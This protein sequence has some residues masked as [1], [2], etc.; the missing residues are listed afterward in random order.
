MIVLQYASAMLDHCL[1]VVGIDCAH[2]KN[3]ELEKT[4]TKRVLL[5]RMFC[6]IL[7]S[8]TVTNNMIILAISLTFGSENTHH[9][10]QFL[11]F[12]V[13][14]G[15]QQLN[16]KNIVIMSDR[17]ASIVQAVSI[18]LPHAYHAYCCTHIKRNLEKE[19]GGTK[20]FRSTEKYF[21]QA[22]NA[23]TENLY[24]EAM[25]DMQKHCIKMFEYL[26]N[27]NHWQL[28]QA[29]QRGC[30]LYDTSSNNVIEQ[31]FSF[32]LQER[33]LS[34]IFFLRQIF[35]KISERFQHMREESRDK[36]YALTEYARSIYNR[37][38]NIAQTSPF[39]VTIINDLTYK[40]IVYS[41]VQNFARGKLWNIDFINNTCDCSK[42]QQTGIPCEHAIRCY[43]TI[44]AHKT[45]QHIQQQ[46]NLLDNYL[47]Y[48]DKIH[49]AKSWTN[50]LELYNDKL[51]MYLPSDN[52][53]NEIALQHHQQF[54]LL[55][56]QLRDDFELPLVN[57]RIRGIGET[58]GGVPVSTIGK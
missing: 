53:I 42:W 34:P 2:M 46:M 10:V 55:T 25:N 43:Q 32:I 15:L 23:T 13:K 50:A 5:G 29:I 54:L 4:S 19:L 3:I 56:P 36:N 52:V 17:G 45:F 8:R 28:Y 30:K 16:H 39:T 6:T 41:T 57:T 9:L 33:Y 24:E 37:N 14:H 40:F 47:K 20:A 58:S 51:T 27:L 1:P 26:K 22:R 31:V 21:W 11:D 48:F 44:G 38:E 7:S 35:Y 49:H 18:V 12:C